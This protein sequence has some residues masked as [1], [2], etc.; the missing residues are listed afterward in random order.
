MPFSLL[1]A[2]G[3]LVSDLIPE[4]AVPLPTICISHCASF[5]IIR[6]RFGSYSRSA[7]F[8]FDKSIDLIGQSIHPLR[9]PDN[10]QASP[11]VSISKTGYCMVGVYNPQILAVIL[12]CNL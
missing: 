6:Q 7:Y 8:F 9:N 5:V 11:L 3:K 12:A 4:G 2:I 10:K 1:K